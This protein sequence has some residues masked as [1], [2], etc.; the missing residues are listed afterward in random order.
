MWILKIR[1]DP[2][3]N[4]HVNEHT[5]VCSQ[6]FASDDFV[7]LLDCSSIRPHLKPTA[8]PSIFPWSKVHGRTT[9][10]SKIAFSAKQRKDVDYLKGE[11]QCSDDEDVSVND[12][13][14]DF[15]DHEDPL[16]SCDIVNELQMLRLRVSQLQVELDS[17]R[18]FATASLF[19]LE[20]IKAKEE[21]VK[22][23]TGFSD[24]A[25]LLAF[26]ETLLESDAAV[27]RQ[28]DGK[29]SKKSYDES[30]CGRPCILSMLEQFFL[31]LVR[32]R[33]G[34]LELDLAQRF[35]ISQATVSRIVTTWINLLYHTFKG[36]EK[37]PS[38][39]IVKKYMPES[40]KNE[41]PNTRIIIDATEFSVQ[42]PSSLLTQASTFSAYK[43]R[44]TIKVLIGITPSGVISFVSKCYEGSISDRKLVELSGL[45]EKLEPGDDIMAD[46]G[47][48]IQDLLAP[49]GVRL[50]MP[51]FLSGNTQMPESDV[52][53][54]KKVAHLRIHVE[55]AIGRVKD[56]R[57]LKDTLPAT[58][59][60]SI[61]EIV[62][63]CC[64]L[65]NFSPPLVS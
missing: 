55:R 27:M 28:W 16:N 60:D 44:N 61:N 65:S 5:R 29:N 46:K 2:G 57:I 42:R 39:H 8:I 52:I 4:F 43:N 19:R 20:N 54:T 13:T 18:K 24:Y 45:L 59:W 47:F 14:V 37:F 63:V 53:L 34:L 41:Y 64:M 49:L 62:Y 36:I 9:L 3:P 30:K 15:A 23:Y 50:N 21:L 38:W 56:F 1:R 11:I 33:L 6:H 31:T 48:Q 32:L 22:F 17:A 26:Y 7:T 35:G 58:M 10:T 40:F 25:T 12:E 51:P